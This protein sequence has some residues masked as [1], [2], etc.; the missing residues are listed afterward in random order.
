MLAGSP[1]P[2][3]LG[4][5][6]CRTGWGLTFRSQALWQQRW[7]RPG[8]VVTVC[9]VKEGWSRYW[10]ANHSAHRHTS[11]QMPSNSRTAD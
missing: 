4:D 7:A 9:T 11:Q 6:T 3:A 1:W 2:T 5:V 8:H 10:G